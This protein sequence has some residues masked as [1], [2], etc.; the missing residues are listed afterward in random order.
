M[1]ASTTVHAGALRLTL[2]TSS[3]ALSEPIVPE[4]TVDPTLDISHNVLNPQAIS[5]KHGI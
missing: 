1:Y 5:T 2:C 4:A 3:H